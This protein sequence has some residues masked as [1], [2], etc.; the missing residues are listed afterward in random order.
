M[1]IPDAS[2]KADACAASASVRRKRKRSQLNIEEL[3]V[4]IDAPEPPSKKALRKARKVKIAQ[5]AAQKTQGE[6]SK[7][8]LND[9]TLKTPVS[10]STGPGIW[11]GNLPWSVTKA[12]VRV[13]ITQNTEISNDMI[14]R[15]YMPAPSDATNAASQQRV[16]PKNKGFA[17]V[18]FST[19]SALAH[20]IALS[21]TL[22][23][24]RRVLIKDSKSFEGRPE[25]VK[26]ESVAAS[27]QPGKPP[28]KR[29]FIGNLGFETSKED[30]QNHFNRCGNILDVHIAT[31]E[32]SGKCKGYAWVEFEDLEAGK[33]AVRGWIDY[34]E[35]KISDD[36][37]NSNEEDESS[38]DPKQ[39]P[40][41]K[42]P[43]KQRK[44]WVNKLKGRPLRMEFA[45]DPKTR[46]N[47][48]HGKGK[49]RPGRK[50]NDT[51]PNAAD[52]NLET[53]TSTNNN[54]PPNQAANPPPNT[55]SQTKPS[56]RKLDTRT[57]KPGAAL[58][59]APR[60]TG[61]IV[62]SEGKKTTFG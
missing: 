50:N 43:R 52:S 6:D 2:G 5:P 32:D 24:G 38:E 28:S 57:I 26:E 59:A 55:Q 13:F 58:A 40:H 48:R 19:E 20:A 42:K 56:T 17:Y 8:Q 34:D 3:E 25:K 22:L 4:D 16:K 18:D 35:T 27:A 7:S 53:A 15:I 1:G 9:A 49:D 29:I 61:G 44:W 21:E 41:L 45:E 23:N 12:D 31:F 51:I 11:I 33:A 54:K 39:K 36:N 10:K 62:A 60:L 47:K 46:Y 37:N 14:T 30:L